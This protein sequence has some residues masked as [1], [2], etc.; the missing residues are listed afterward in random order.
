MA[1]A[2]TA[3]GGEVHVAHCVCHAA[4]S[5]CQQQQPGAGEGSPLDWAWPPVAQQGGWQ[6][7]ALQPCQSEVDTEHGSEIEAM[8]GSGRGHGRRQA[9]RA[10]HGVGGASQAVAHVAQA[11]SHIGCVADAGVGALQPPLW[12]G[13]CAGEEAGT[14]LQ[15]L[16]G[17]QCLLSQ[18]VR[19]AIF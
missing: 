12:V 9:A 19:V 6:G 14:G 7:V 16:A 1:E 5:W 3:G 4:A 8:H 10:E 15:G 2:V 11:G 17:Q 18:P 13:G